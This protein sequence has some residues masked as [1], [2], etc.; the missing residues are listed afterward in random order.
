MSIHVK[1]K[2]LKWDEMIVEKFH[3][4]GDTSLAQD[5]M[6]EGARFMKEESDDELDCE[7]HDHMV[8]SN[9]LVD[10]LIEQ[11]TSDKDSHEHDDE[12]HEE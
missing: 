3:K 11:E 2:I 6:E 10:K 8:K 9:R 5:L 7:C 1:I 12:N 4:T